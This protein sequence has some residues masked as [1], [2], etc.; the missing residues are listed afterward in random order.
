MELPVEI[1]IEVVRTRLE[2]ALKKAENERDEY[3]KLVAL[4]REENELL[5]RGLLGQKAERLPTNDAQLSLEILGLLGAGLPPAGAS[6]PEPERETVTYQRRKPTGRKIPDPETLPRVRIELI[7]DDVAKAGRDNF[8]EIGDEVRHVM[9][10]RP[11]SLVLVEVHRPKFAPKGRVRGEGTEISTAAPIETPIP[12]GSAGP[13]L[14]ADTIVRRWQDHLPLNR[15]EAIYEREGLRLARSTLCT[16]HDQL[17]PLAKPIVDAMW[18]D[19]LVQPYLCSDST[20]VL[21]QAKEKC[22]NGHFWVVVAPERHALFRYT[23][24]HDS[25]AVDSILKTYRGYLVADATSVLDHLYIDGTIVEVGCWA[26]SRRYFFKALASDPQR[27]KHALAKISAIFRI[28]RESATLP[29]KKKHEIRQSR[30]KPIVDEFFAWCDAELPLLLDEMPIAK[31]VGYARNQR[32]ALSRFLDEPMLPLHNNASELQLRR[33]VVGRKNW[34]FVG[35]DDAGEVNATFVSL[36]ASCAMHG[37]EPW[38][39]LRDILCLLPDWNSKRVIELAPVNWRETL[40]KQETQQALDENYFRRVTLG[41][42]LSAA[43]PAPAT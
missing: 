35:S 19:A 21:V 39:Y 10:R 22:R 20:G 33:E 8:D 32:A 6:T 28:E 36:L 9:E 31:A 18:G 26:H 7:P 42:D 1:E 15:L 27:A 5:K 34:L 40:Q 29:R 14:L 13:G 12:R 30:S 25:A 16:W 41:G 17:L 43:T 2:N 24:K 11:A 38:T 3:K 4:L 37:I 23:A